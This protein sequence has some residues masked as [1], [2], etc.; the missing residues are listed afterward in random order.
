MIQNIFK[1]IKPNGML[2]TSINGMKWFKNLK[3]K[4]SFSFK[5]FFFYKLIE[6]NGNKH[7]IL[8]PKELNNL[9]KK[10][11]IKMSINDKLC[12]LKKWKKLHSFLV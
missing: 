6:I 7:N 5:K 2:I 1:S 9:S 8:L 11:N 3:P 10:H 4:L 12:Y